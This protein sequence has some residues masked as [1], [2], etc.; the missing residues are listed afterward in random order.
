MEAWRRLKTD[1]NFEAKGDSCGLLEREG[2]TSME[3]GSLPP[4]QE[5]AEKLKAE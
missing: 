4:L 5:P 1:K 3:E 2:L